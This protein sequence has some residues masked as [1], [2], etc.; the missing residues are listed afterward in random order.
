MVFTVTVTATDSDGFTAQDSIIIYVN[1]L[2]SP[3][4]V[5]INP[6]QPTSSDDLMVNILV[7]SVD[8]ESDPI[9]Y[10]YNWIKSGLSAPLS[11][12]LFPVQT[13]RGDEWE[14]QV[15]P[16]D[17]YGSGG[18]DS[19]SIV[20][21]NSPPG[22][23]SLDISPTLPTEA[24]VV[25]CT[26]TGSFDEDGDP[27]SHSFDW[28]INGTSIGVLTPSLDSSH[29]ANGDSIQCVVTPNDGIENGS[30]FT[31][32]AIVVQ[33]SAPTLGSVELQPLPA[34]ESSVLNCLPLNPSDADGDT[35]SFIY[36]WL[37]NGQSINIPTSSL[38]GSYFDKSDLVE[39]VVTP[40]DGSSTGA[41]LTSNGTISGRFCMDQ[42]YLSPD[43]A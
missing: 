4:Q 20:I 17:G 16:H 24:D 43:P 39:C 18:L 27:I 19:A 42:S 37:I 33:N 38:D 22:I 2:P 36:D 7:P 35:V 5:E 12:Q 9:T 3:P 32:S 23:L 41:P 26:V 6:N 25:T 40:T 30:A 1:D 11:T 13:T 34:Y 14:L 21:G 10:T 31:S 28:L 15:I 8:L 29:F